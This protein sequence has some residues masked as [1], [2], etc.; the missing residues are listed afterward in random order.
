LRLRHPT[1]V[2]RERDIAKGIKPQF[3]HR[4]SMTH[5]ARH[6]IPLAEES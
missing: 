3:N 1:P 2:A 4:F 5:A 6:R